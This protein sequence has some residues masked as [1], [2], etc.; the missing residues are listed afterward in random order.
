MKENQN[1]FEAFKT[2]IIV[3]IICVM[4]I[5]FLHQEVIKYPLLPY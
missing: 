4:F 3:I 2:L 5:R 1:Y